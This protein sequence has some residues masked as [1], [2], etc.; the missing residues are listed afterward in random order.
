MKLTA[1]ELQFSWAGV[2]VVTSFLCVFMEELN[3]TKGKGNVKIYGIIIITLYFIYGMF[4]LYFLIS[5]KKPTNI[6]KLVLWILFT[7]ITGLAGISKIATQERMDTYH[8][9]FIEIAMLYI[10]Y[11]YQNY[12]KNLK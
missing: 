8:F 9:I 4:L 10:L 11:L 3:R 1:K 6:D 12:Y 7:L 2:L 5:T